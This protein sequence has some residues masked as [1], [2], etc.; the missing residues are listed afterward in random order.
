[1]SYELFL[2]F[3]Y[4]RARPRQ[5]LARA[6]ALA[7]IAGVAFGVAALIVTTAIANGF[8]DE[9]RDKILRGTA[10]ITLMRADGR[11]IANYQAVV[12]RLQ[13]L[14]GVSAAF[15]TTYNGALLTGP[16]GSAYAVLRGV[17]VNSAQSVSDIS[18]TINEGSV[19]SLGQ[20]SV[21]DIN[22]ASSTGKGEPQTAY[23]P[24]IIVGVELAKRTGLAVGV[25]GL[26]ISGDAR[27]LATGGTPR[28]QRV[29]VTGAFR[30]GLYDYDSSWV[31]LVLDEA[32]EISGAPHTASVISIHVTEIYDTSRVTQ[33]V[34]ALMGDEYTTIDWQEAN[35]P[36]FAAL[37]LERRMV[38]LIISLITLVAALNITTALVLLVVEKRSDIAILS[39]MGARPTSIMSVFLIEGG[40]VGLIGTL[41]GALLGIAACALGN[42]YQLVSL[43]GEVY[44]LSNIPFHLRATDVA[45]A[46]LVAFAL[47]L[48]AT[49]FPARA[50]ASLRP[51]EALRES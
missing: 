27:S 29:R 9:M 12:S 1:M 32:A 19:T 4:L 17:D 38:I 33:E 24:N 23:I 26:I 10:H 28:E 13:S 43:P 11:P 35:R 36:L 44:S 41:A 47:S 39:A 46:V 25:E 7:A 6:T 49:V 51:V 37:E 2:A 21:A 40:I 16:N 48:I 15:P 45:L 20:T 5:R 50:A 18:P 3:R 42:Y 22:D 14:K 30:S 34:H 31:Y 8:R